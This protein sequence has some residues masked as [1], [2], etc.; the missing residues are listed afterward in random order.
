[1][2][3]SIDRDSKE[4]LHVPITS[5]QGANL[6]LVQMAVVTIPARPTNG[7]WTA[8]AWDEAA[9]VATLLVGPYAAPAVMSV[10]VRITDNPE[11]PVFQ[12]GTI[13]VT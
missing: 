13:A 5:P 1:M 9:R 7:D 10:W 4:Y 2:R 3:T 12:A 8:A 11:V 6:S